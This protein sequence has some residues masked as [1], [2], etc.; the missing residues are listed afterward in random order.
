HAGVAR[1]PGSLRTLMLAQAAIGVVDAAVQ[2][3][4]GGARFEF[5]ERILVQQRDGTVI[6]LAPTLRI[7]FAEQADGIV[8]PAPPQVAGQRPEPFLDG[9]DE[10]VEGT[11]FA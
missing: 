9:R 7:E 4:F 3:K 6:E 11:G 10:T 8:I 1:T 2:G 5:G